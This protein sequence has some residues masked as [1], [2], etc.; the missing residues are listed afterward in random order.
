MATRE[1]IE[2]QL[3]EGTVLLDGYDEA[4]VGMSHEGQ[5]VYDYEKMIDVLRERDGMTA[6]PHAD[7]PISPGG[8]IRWQRWDDPS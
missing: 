7:H 2:E 8:I 4:Y 3:E 5:A 1:Q 6:S